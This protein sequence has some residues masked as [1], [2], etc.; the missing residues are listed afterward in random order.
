M[1]V[2][3]IADIYRL[4]YTVNA[5]SYLAHDLMIKNVWRCSSEIISSI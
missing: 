3:A 5:E 1:Y 4:I 2:N